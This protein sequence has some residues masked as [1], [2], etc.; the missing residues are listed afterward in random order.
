MGVWEGVDE[1]FGASVNQ[2]LGQWLQGLPVAVACVRWE[3]AD[4][5]SATRFRFHLTA[6]FRDVN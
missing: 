6:A 1:T 3:G 5:R 2:S 4:E